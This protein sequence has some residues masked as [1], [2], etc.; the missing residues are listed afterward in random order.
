MNGVSR[1]RRWLTI[2]LTAGMLMIATGGAAVAAPTSA[3]TS[4]PAV[5]A[6]ADDEGP[7]FLSGVVL[8]VSGSVVGD[9]YASGQSITISGDVVGDVIAAAQTITITGTV[10][11]DV[12]LFAQDVTISGEVSRSASVAAANLTVAETGSLGDDVVAAAGTIDLAGDVGRD[13]VASVGRLTIEGTVGGDVTYVSDKE[14]SIG[15][16]AVDGTVE[17]VEPP[18][19]PRMEVSPWAIFLGWFL[20]AVYG[21]VALSLIMLLAALLVPRWLDR[22]TDRLMPSPWKALLVGFVASIAVPFALLLTA[23][24]IIGAPLALA[25]ALVWTV[26]VLA[27]FVFSAY[28]LGRLLLRDRHHP[29]LT[30]LL[31]GAILIVALQIPWLNVVVWLAMVFFGL[32]A[33]LL[34][35]HHQRPWH[36]EGAPIREP[37][38]RSSEPVTPMAPP[39]SDTPPHL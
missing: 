28:Y 38:E 27:T 1:M 31:G 33:Q 6:L 24:T 17:R 36:R 26:M 12:R 13:V 25:G 11:G 14:A 39:P 35:I 21:F 3:P 5:S 37:S 15:A 7:H 23:L 34:A 2:L 20:G 8:D 4:G 30:G 29:V 16:T 18:Q 32:G 10:D 19:T 9:V 22:V